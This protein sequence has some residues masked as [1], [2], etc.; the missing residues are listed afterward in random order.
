MSHRL[1]LPISGLLPALM[2]LFLMVSPHQQDNRFSF[3]LSSHRIFT[4]EGSPTFRLDALNL[5]EAVRFRV[6]KVT[7]PV[8][9]FTSRRDVMV[10]GFLETKEDQGEWQ[11]IIR[12]YPIV[13]EWEE[14][15]KRQR[16]QWTSLEI[17]LGISKSGVY[18]VEA[19]AHGKIAYTNVIVSPYALIT[20][21][22]RSQLLSYVVDSKTGAAVGNADIVV[23]RRYKKLAAGKSSE[24]GLF[25]TS[26]P[27][28]KEG[29]EEP[30]P[31]MRGGTR[32]IMMNNYQLLV[33]AERGSHFVIARPWWYGY[34]LEREYLIYSYTERPVY[35]PGQ[36]VFFKG[37]VRKKTSG[38]E[39]VPVSNTW[40]KAI[41]RDARG[42]EVHSDS[43]RTNANGTFAG[44]IMLADPA[45]LG[46]YQLETSI[47]GGFG[48]ASFD[49]QEYK[50]P[51]YD[52]TVST[53][54]QHYA[55]GETVRA[56][57]KGMY[58]FGS[59]V[60][61]AQVEYMV[62]R[63]RYW[64]PWWIGTEYEWFYESDAATYSY[65]REMI[66]TGKG[67]LD[68][69]GGLDFPIDTDKNASMDYVYRI[70]AKVT[71]LSRRSI[72]GEVSVE[73]TRGLFLM[74]LHADKHVYRPGEDARLTISL[75]DF[76]AKGVAVPYVAT[77]TREWWEQRTR[78]QNGRRT[79]DYTHRSEPVVTVTG[80]ADAMGISAVEIA[81]EE[82]GYYALSV[83]ATDSIGNTVTEAM[84]IYVAGK[85][86]PWWSGANQGIQVIPD[87][88]SYEVGET[89]HA[90]IILPIAN[91]DVLL[92][93]EADRIIDYKVEHSEGSTKTI[94][95]QIKNANAPNFFL[96]VTA[97]VGEQLYQTTKQIPVLPKEKF[98][99]VEIL[100]DKE[101]Y[102][103]GENGVVRLKAIDTRGRPV[104]DAELSLG[105]VD[106]SLYAI[107]PEEVPDIRRFFYANRWNT[108]QTASSLYFSSYG[109][110]RLEM[111]A[112]GLAARAT[113]AVL[114]EAAPIATTSLLDHKPQFIAA[115][116]RKDFRDMLQ[117]F[118][119]VVTD[120]R[121]NA[122]VRVK[123][124][125]NLT[126]WRATARVVT[127]DT[128]V[129]NTTATVVV[130]KNLLVRI[131]TPRFLTQR[132]STLIATVVH[133]YLREDKT[134]KLS[135]T[136]SG[137]S[138]DGKEK[139]ITIP[140]NGQVR[141]DWKLGAS[142]AG[143][144]TLTA[145]A[146]TN[147]ESDAM[148]V[149]LPVLPHGVQ[150]A[151]S[152]VVNLQDP[153]EEKSVLITIPDEAD[154]STAKVSVDLSPSLASSILTALDDLVGY[155]YG[156]VEQT[157]SRFLPTIV[158]ANAMKD[159]NAPLKMSNKEDLPKMVEKGLQ[160]L[161][162]F[163]H[164]D[165]GW[166][167]WENDRTDPF[168]T[169]YVVYGLTL[170]RTAGNSIAE[171]V[172]NRGIERVQ[173]LL[174]S[175]EKLDATTQAYA[176]YVLSF[177]GA[178]GA[179]V[180]KS[181]LVNQIAKLDLAKANN[182]TRS[183]VALASYYRGDKATAASVAHVLEASVIQTGTAAFW[184]GK[185]W[186]Y[187]W[188]DDN[189]ETTAFVLKALLAAR[190]NSELVQKAVHW[191]L[192]QKQGSSWLSTKQTAIVIFGLVDYLKTSKE[193][194]PDYTVTLAVNNI[195]IQ[196][197]RMTKATL[198]EKEPK[199]EV[200][201]DVLKKG[202]NTLRVE[203]KG[204]G[205][206]YCSV[207]ESYYSTEEN[208]DAQ[209]SGVSVKREYFKLIRVKKGDRYVY[210][211]QPLVGSRHGGLP[212]Y[213]AQG[214]DEIFVK[215]TLSSDGNYEYFMLEDPHAPG[216]EVVKEEANY[217]IVGEK[218][219]QHHPSY[220]GWRYWWASKEVH[221]EKVGF[222]ARSISSG[223]YTFSYIVRAQ[224]PG[225]YHVMPAL[226]SLMYYPEVRGNSEEMHVIINE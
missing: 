197:R 67:K 184:S 145:Q 17:S 48:I 113:G 155:P 225:R 162:A 85:N 208:I 28:M 226:G 125:D 204:E 61:G 132:D 22:S 199:V 63:S 23:F 102:R 143:T 182:Y 47:S 96:G 50:K 172:L 212:G 163:Q 148:E 138:L 121:G 165:G 134:A 51:E 219:Y 188:Q 11:K 89:M 131:E 189:V 98:L 101:S 215:L 73:V 26:L 133:N 178:N 46:T 10:P 201:G 218:E 59:P 40:M 181:T 62:Y 211:K 187:N 175:P 202:I 83:S 221:D 8:S 44:D 86:Y 224:I 69:E 100:Y 90:L 223:T 13:R 31:L 7:D 87:K 206:L 32:P 139:M 137:A 157:M 20:K 75:K 177:A 12:D 14:R 213:A 123:Y 222:F 78:I 4:P 106:E 117:W 108:I 209:R 39:L 168:M 144:V 18:L 76:E 151:R 128:K 210:E 196:R 161:Y 129:G 24:K 135:L 152:Q 126:T 79:Y 29:E 2:G 124:P 27:P 205:K 153:N 156:C 186:H 109:Y 1:R 21:Q 88:E 42:T 149:R 95:F 170:A 118:P 99:R 166:G 217:E 72:S 169:S 57:V 146:L 5:Q 220:S 174:N 34:G 142:E 54:K 97:L 154:L 16:D 136:A 110:G 107:L 38:G 180:D 185:A 198:F 33:M 171:G 173:S 130:R 35:R 150:I 214:G 216:F 122:Q 74:T 200:S 55:K 53:D 111:A 3:S 104:R 84:N 167:W 114:K 81:L 112:D 9:F 105:I 65:Q 127:S 179:S 49:V 80:T 52:V 19:R 36:Q 56:T 77:V 115:V 141:I 140:K 193:L 66:L 37:I 30:S 120:D 119:A 71:D 6:Y 60:S 41:V 43:L 192:K 194:E 159:L 164:Q 25:F 15:V 103:P 183:L 58:Y 45:P 92:S 64:R 190:G 147:E 203:K 70:D 68:D 191:L 94:S 207:R 93:A 82:P 195:N 160:R 116:L 176:I 91:V 158:V